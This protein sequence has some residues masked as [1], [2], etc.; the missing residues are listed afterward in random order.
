MSID[1]YRKNL[2]ARRA[3]HRERQRLAKQE[4]DRFDRKLEE[5]LNKDGI[6]PTVLSI[7]GVYELIAEEYNNA[8][9]KALEEEKEDE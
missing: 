2:P 5:L 6:N 8:V 1:E 9:L 3:R 7:P 4:R